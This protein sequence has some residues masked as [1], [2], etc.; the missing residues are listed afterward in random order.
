[1]K[2]YIYL[3]M[4]IKEKIKKIKYNRISK[5]EKVLME[6]FSSL[7]LKYVNENIINFYYND[8]YL[9]EYIIDSCIIVYDIDKIFIEFKNNGIVDN[10]Q[11]D[12]VTEIVKKLLFEYFNINKINDYLFVF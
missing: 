1:M 12:K 2:N 7:Q 9:I 10:I 4:Q 3:S 11:K 6:I 8:Y 5:E